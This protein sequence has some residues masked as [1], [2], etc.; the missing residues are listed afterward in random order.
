MI[1]QKVK[2]MEEQQNIMIQSN[3]TLHERIAE[4]Q[5]ESMNL[6][7]D[8]VSMHKQRIKEKLREKFV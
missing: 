7:N 6:K 5:Q 1:E 2:R 8:L 3:K 4:L